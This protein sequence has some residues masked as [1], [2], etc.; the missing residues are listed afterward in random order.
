MSENQNNEEDKLEKQKDSQK[1]DD[2]EAYF[3]EI[4]TLETDFSDLDDIDLEELKDIQQAI[5][6]VKEMTS[7]SNEKVVDI[8]FVDHLENT[9]PE[10]EVGQLDEL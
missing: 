4:K 1:A 6:K 2:L 3:S 5:S 10:A 7:T 9:E 8:N